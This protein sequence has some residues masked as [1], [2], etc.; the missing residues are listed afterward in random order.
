MKRARSLSR[1]LHLAPPLRRVPLLLQR[2]L[3]HELLRQ[4]SNFDHQSSTD[5]TTPLNQQHVWQLYSRR[6]E[7]K[8]A[9]T[10]CV[11]S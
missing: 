5:G 3:T 1:A 8:C 11:G 9:A 2:P 10:A 7:K 6:R 4:K